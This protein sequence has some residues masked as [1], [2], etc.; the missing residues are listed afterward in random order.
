MFTVNPS[1][2]FVHDIDVHVPVDGGY[3]PQKLKTRFYVLTTEQLESYDLRDP[4][5]QAAF[6]N[7]AVVEFLDLQS[8]DGSPVLHNDKVKAGLI[9]TPYVRTALMTH[10]SLA[11]TVGGRKN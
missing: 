11:V 7:A 6:C 2:T 10:Y 3:E 4:A 1:P 5:Q 8:P 9:N